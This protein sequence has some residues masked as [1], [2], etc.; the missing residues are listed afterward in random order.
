M[1]ESINLIHFFVDSGN[2]FHFVGPKEECEF[3]PAVVLGNG[4]FNLR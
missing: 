1:F 4:C 3:W 2:L